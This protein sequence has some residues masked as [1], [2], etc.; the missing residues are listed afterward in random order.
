MKKRKTNTGL[1][2]FLTEPAS[3]NS[4]LIDLIETFANNFEHI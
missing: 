3:G 4:F 2:G 1:E